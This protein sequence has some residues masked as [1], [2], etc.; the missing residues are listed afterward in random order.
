MRLVHRTRCRNVVLADGL[1]QGKRI[2]YQGLADSLHTVLCV[3][4]FNGQ[5]PCCP[6]NGDVVELPLPGALAWSDSWH[7]CWNRSQRERRGVYTVHLL[8]ADH[9]RSRFGDEQV[10]NP[11]ADLAAA[12]CVAHIQRRAVHAQVLPGG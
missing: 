11:N 12:L 8:P 6:Q 3:T 2:H 4:S 1:I 7:V 10:G 9:L 5:E